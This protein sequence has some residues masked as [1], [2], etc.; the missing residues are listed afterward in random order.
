MRT[1]LKY[2]FRIAY[3]VLLIALIGLPAIASAE[4]IFLNSELSGFQEV[5]SV[6]SNARGFFQAFLN[7]ETQTLDY[8]LTYNDLSSAPNAAHIHF[9]QPGVNGG[10]VVFLCGA[11]GGQAC[12]ATGTVSG[13]LSLQSIIGPADQGIAPGDFRSFLRAILAGATYAN[14]HTANFPT[15]EIRGQLNI[16]LDISPPIA[17]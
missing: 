7:T 16:D 13:S 9:G 11:E 4:T 6:A 8:E 5:P 2:R 10:V 12:P 14:V 15:G 1:Q 3:A 17:E